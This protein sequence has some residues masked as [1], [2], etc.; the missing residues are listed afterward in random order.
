M[1]IILVDHHGLVCGHEV[2][3]VDERVLSPV[4]LHL[5]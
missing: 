5:L 2:L 1:L 3:D 4:H